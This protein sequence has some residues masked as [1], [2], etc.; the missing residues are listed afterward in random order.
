M[1]PAIVLILFCQGAMSAAGIVLRQ[2]DD[3]KR[4]LAIGLAIALGLFPA[5]Q[6]FEV[7]QKATA[8]SPYEMLHRG[9]Y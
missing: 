3:H 7:W 9:T 5:W 8:P 2:E 1:L 4:M 6:T